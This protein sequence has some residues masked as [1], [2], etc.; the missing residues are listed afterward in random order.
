[1]E[2][3]RPSSFRVLSLV[4]DRLHRR[5]FWLLLAVHGLAAIAPDPGRRARGLVFGS[6]SILGEPFSISLP[7]VL[8]FLLLGNSGFGV[9]AGGMKKLFGNPRPLVFGL[10][11]NIVLPLLF[12]AG[13]R[14]ALGRWHNREE[15]E[16]LVM[17]LGLVAAMPIA[18][19]SAAWC[20]NAGGDMALSLGL[21]LGSTALSPFAGS[22]SLHVVAAMVGGDYAEDLHE[23]AGRSMGVFLS[24]CVV[25]PSVLGILFRR[26]AGEGVFEHLRPAL[27]PANELI[28][29]GLLYMNASISLPYAFRH[30]DPDFLAMLL[31][32]SGTLCLLR[33]QCGEWLGRL[34]RTSPSERTALVFALG[35][36]N[37]GGGLT[38]ATIAI[39]DH[40]LAILPIV[41]YT[42]L[43]QLTAA[44]YY[45]YRIPRRDQ[46]EAGDSGRRATRSGR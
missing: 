33:F 13:L 24:L 41:F 7:V 15:A 35:M 29:L 25:L 5:F 18:G 34:L 45:S 37:N 27:R 14:A 38:L 46:A 1:M 40:P 17:G 39:P 6:V 2:E 8:L 30:F 9:S 22:L 3:K 21:V 16:S 20:Q 12:L 36:N 4:L 19:A 44:W 11:V 23:M 32:G 10:L 43:Q 26:L 31:V 28:L 42:L